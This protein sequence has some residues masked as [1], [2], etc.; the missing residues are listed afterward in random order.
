MG[1]E[2]YYFCLKHATWF[3]FERPRFNHLHTFTFCRNVRQNWHTIWLLCD[4]RLAT[5]QPPPAY[6]KA[7]ESIGSAE[8]RRNFCKIS[9]PDVAKLMSW[10]FRSAKHDQV[11]PKTAGKEELKIMLGRREEKLWLIVA[12]ELTVLYCSTLDIY[13]IVAARHVLV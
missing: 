8:G 5:C 2:W 6:T 13:V 9:S 12:I 4:M 3:Y 1:D 7:C 10:M 11:P